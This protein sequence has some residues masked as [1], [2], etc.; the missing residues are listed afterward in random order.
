MAEIQSIAVSQTQSLS[1]SKSISASYERQERASSLSASLGQGNVALSPDGFGRVFDVIDISDEAR[2]QLL[3]D[4]ADAE[5]LAAF[6]QGERPQV[7]SAPLVIQDGRVQVNALAAQIAEQFTFTEAY[8]L[9]FLQETTL[10]I[11]TDQ[12]SIEITQSRLVEASIS[13]TVTLEQSASVGALQAS[14]ENA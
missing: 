12:G 8:D 14:F 5:R 9:S 1:L 10:E 4:R 13:S 6:V 7:L 3:Q 2:Q 11:E